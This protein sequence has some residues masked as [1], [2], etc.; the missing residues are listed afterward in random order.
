MANPEMSRSNDVPQL[1]TLVATDNAVLHQPARTVALPLDAATRALVA[2]MLFSVLPEQLQR[3][4]APWPAAA[5]MA[6]P[7]WGE[8]LRY[9]NVCS[10][11]DSH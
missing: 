8:P 4:H 3:A 9:A 11:L 7:Q 2:S 10:V 1:L 6:A 5:G